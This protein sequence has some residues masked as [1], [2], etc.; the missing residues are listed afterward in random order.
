MLIEIIDEKPVFTQEEPT[1]NLRD[2]VNY[3]ET[4]KERALIVFINNKKLVRSWGNINAKYPLLINLG[5]WVSLMDK[6]EWDFYL[7]DYAEECTDELDLQIKN[8][9]IIYG[10][11][12]HL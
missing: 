9:K 2:I 6:G 12:W 11:I 1:N 7:K 5:D 10:D 3:L 8:G 4:Y